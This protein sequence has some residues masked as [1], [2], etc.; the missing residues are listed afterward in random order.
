MKKT[1]ITLLALSGLAM[2][3]DTEGLLFTT[4]NP[5]AY[6]NSAGIGGVA[7]QLADTTRMDLTQGTL[8]LSLE[9]VELT[10]IT[11][12]VSSSQNAGWN[13]D[14]AMYILDQDKHLIAVSEALGGTDFSKSSNQT[15]TF[16]DTASLVVY[17]GKD[18]K[19]Q[20]LTLGNQYYAY[21]VDKSVFSN[22]TKAIGLIGMGDTLNWIDT[23]DVNVRLYDYND[24]TSESS[25][26]LGNAV[27]NNGS[28]RAHSL[29]YDGR[30]GAV[31][32]I[33]TVPEPATA[34]LSLLALAGLATRR[35]RK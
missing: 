27:M 35:R 15:F 16:N 4:V 9:K 11:L 12:Q 7:F 5:N 32:S 26:L 17:Q 24:T 21:I 19:N 1:L 2:A 22:T 10:S 29:K 13:A 34:T 6:S 33:A 8:S 25:V 14:L 31:M 18:N 20:A 23:A 30:Y 3:D 28:T